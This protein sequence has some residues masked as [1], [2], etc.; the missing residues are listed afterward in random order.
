MTLMPGP[1]SCEEKEFIRAIQRTR[2]S[3]TI[4]DSYRPTSIEL[5]VQV[6]SKMSLCQNSDK[7]FTVVN[8][9]LYLNLS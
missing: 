8:D 1:R 2:K 5:S 9:V 7:Y 4:C 6:A 3:K